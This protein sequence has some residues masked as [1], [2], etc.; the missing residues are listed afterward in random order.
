VA[1]EVVENTI[2]FQCDVHLCTEYEVGVEIQAHRCILMF[3]PDT[4]DLELPTSF[5]P[6]RSSYLPQ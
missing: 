2:S 5:V 6:V 4:V 3:T 1:Y